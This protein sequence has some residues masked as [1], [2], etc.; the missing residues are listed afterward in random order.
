ME[1]KKEIELKY[2]SIIALKSAKMVIR[3][4]IF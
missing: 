1:L 2:S 4:K 3:V